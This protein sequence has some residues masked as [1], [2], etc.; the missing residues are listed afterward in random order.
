M[1]LKRIELQL[2]H[3]GQQPEWKQVESR[4]VCVCVFNDAGQLPHTRVELS[5]GEAARSEF[6][7]FY[8]KAQ[9]DLS[10]CVIITSD[11]IKS[12]GSPQ[13]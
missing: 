12:F 2:Q 3:H 9:S 13:L 6:S 10:A 11:H 7:A 1:M 8:T 4:G 5:G